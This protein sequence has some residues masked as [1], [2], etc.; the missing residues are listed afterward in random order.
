M[1]EPRKEKKAPRSAL[2]PEVK[3][4]R[5]ARIARS[6]SPS[7]RSGR[8]LNGNGDEKRPPSWPVVR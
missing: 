2:D 6:P 8:H 4:K 3:E 5:Q 7:E 1:A